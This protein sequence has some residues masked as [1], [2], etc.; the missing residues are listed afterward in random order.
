MLRGYWYHGSTKGGVRCQWPSVVRPGDLRGSKVAVYNTAA[1][2]P[3][4]HVYKDIHLFLSATDL[5]DGSEMEVG[6]VWYCG[7]FRSDRHCHCNYYR[8]SVSASPK[9]LVS[10]YTWNLLEPRDHSWYWELSGRYVPAHHAA[11]Y[12]SNHHTSGRH[13]DRLDTRKSTHRVYV[14]F[15]DE[16]ESQGWHSCLDGHGILVSISPTQAQQI[17]DDCSTGICTIIKTVLLRNVIRNPGDGSVT[18]GLVNLA[19]WVVLE[20]NIGIIAAS[21]PTLRPLFNKAIREG[22]KSGPSS[23]R[24]FGRSSQNRYKRKTSGDSASRQLDDKS[25]LGQIELGSVQATGSTPRRASYDKKEITV[26][27][28]CPPND[29][30]YKDT[31]RK[32][33]S[34]S[35]RLN[36]GGFYEHEEEVL[37]RV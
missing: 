5:Q 33:E 32:S 21:I 3:L 36:D 16:Q 26:A 22:R 24:Y 20:V 4:S 18:W 23:N 19:I 15:A 9:T 34:S 1:F 6:S 13:F 14:E 12:P 8:D 29:D 7:L 17:T 37:D 28:A 30:S 25:G 27:G 10:A 31:R 2:N 11:L 35:K